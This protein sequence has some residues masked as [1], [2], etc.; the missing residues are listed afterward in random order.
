MDEQTAIL[1][2][3]SLRLLIIVCLDAGMNDEERRT[4]GC[5]MCEPAAILR[6]L[7]STLNPRTWTSWTCLED[8]WEA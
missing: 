4:M 1:R 2:G 3:R 7:M 6:G 8:R 5:V